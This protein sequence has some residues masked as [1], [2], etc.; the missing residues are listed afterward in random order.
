MSQ[1]ILVMRNCVALLQS[2]LKNA[3][4]DSHQIHGRIAADIL[5]H[6]VKMKQLTECQILWHGDE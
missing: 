2:E 3:V 6:K 1:A 4:L 5:L